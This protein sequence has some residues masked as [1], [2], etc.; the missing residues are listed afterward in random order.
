VK[1]LFVGQ[2]NNLQPWFDDVVQAIGEAHVLVLFDPAQPLE[3]QMRN[4]GV[5][6]D[7]GGHAAHRMIDAGAA[8]GVRLWQILG[9][10]LDHFD[11]QYV[12]DRGLPLANTPGPFSSVALAEHALFLMLYF[13][14]DFPT[15]QANIRNGNFYRPMNTELAGSTLGLIGLGAS[16]RELARRALAFDMRI[17][18]LDVAPPLDT[19]N[20]L[21]MTYLGGPEAL[22]TLLEQ[23]DYVSIHVPLTR[24]TRHML[25]AERLSHMRP[26]SVLINVARGEII[27]QAA[28]VDALRA[29]QL[30]GAGLDT[31]AHEP[32][33]ACDP[34]RD[35]DNVVL[36]PHIAGGTTGTSRRRA[37]AVAENIR[38]TARGEPP[39]YAITQVE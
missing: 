8:S 10:G 24:R 19:L 29:G 33:E 14:K 23:S 31:F 21:D 26:S 34:L 15:S 9:T 6:V 12:L 37:Q 25:D 2:A 32:L 27:D 3:A 11:V 17:L 30:R 22:D 20:A 36:T 16:G 13:A 35:L 5:V 4:V 1:V 38:R 39:L 18:G 7:Q 28:L